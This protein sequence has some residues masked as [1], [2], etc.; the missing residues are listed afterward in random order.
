MNKVNDDRGRLVWHYFLLK[1]PT[2]DLERLP[3]LD[4][5][6]DGIELVRAGSRMQ[7]NHVFPSLPQ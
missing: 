5:G 1:V 7:N 4:E 6:W 3:G 2:R